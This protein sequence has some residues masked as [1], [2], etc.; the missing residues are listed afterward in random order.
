M[1]KGSKTKPNYRPKVIAT[2]LDNI[3]IP[4]ERKRGKG[5]TARSL[6]RHMKAIAPPPFEVQGYHV[7]IFVLVVMSA[8]QL[9]GLLPDP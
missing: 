1:A 4:V 3:P 7:I 6:P 2:N 5:H 9:A 8:A